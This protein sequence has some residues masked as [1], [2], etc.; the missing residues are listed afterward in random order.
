[1][2]PGGGPPGPPNCICGFGSVSPIISSNASKYGLLG[3]TQ[4]PLG[5][6]KR[7]YGSKHTMCL[8]KKEESGNHC[9]VDH[10]MKSRHYPGPKSIN[11]S[12]QLSVA[13]SHFT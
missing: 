7:L 11:G 13:V 12:H 8:T 9:P 6:H 2:N 10:L 4:V 1:M 3:F 5:T